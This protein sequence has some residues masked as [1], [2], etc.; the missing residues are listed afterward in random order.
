MAINDDFGLDFSR[1]RVLLVE[2][3]EFALN[4]ARSAL[5]ELGFTTVILA[6][7]GLEAERTMEAFPHFQLIVSDWN[8]PNV[9]G[10]ELLKTA[11][12]RWPGVPFVMLTSNDSVDHVTEA[13]SSGVFAYIIKPFS[14]AG[15]RK[16]IIY[17]IRKRLAQGGE[18]AD[19]TD[20]IYHQ[21]LQDIEA[22]SL[23][24]SLEGG[25]IIKP[26]AE[27]F[28]SALETLLLSPGEREKNMHRLD[29]VIHDMKTS[30]MSDD[31]T[32]KLV[33]AIT[34]QL[35]AFIVGLDAPTPM[36]LE[37]IKLHVETLRTLTSSGAAKVSPAHGKKLMAALAM[38]VA[39]ASH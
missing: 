14:L 3:N 22:V 27:R 10:L 15:M 35:R 12:N 21:A 26:E 19:D 30:V 18:N 20:Q 17:A 11:R 7:D 6:R 37:I 38:A 28:E 5:E 31:N 34:D 8:M 13:Q 16:Q 29:E 23:E 24:K 4:L 25:I 39:K 9:T 2:D 36:E 32:F 1:M 33:E